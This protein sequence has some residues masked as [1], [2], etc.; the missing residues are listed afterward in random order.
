MFY[1]EIYTKKGFKNS[2][3]EHVLSDILGIG[4][5]DITKVEYSPLYVIDGDITS[6]EAETIASEL[7]SDKIIETYICR[8]EKQSKGEGGKIGSPFSVIE[9]WYRKGVTDTVS[10]SVVKAVKDLGILKEIKVKTGH[11]YYLYGKVSQIVLSD[12]A[13]KLLANT[14]VQEYIAQ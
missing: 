12:V 13:T 9:V 7:L 8:S 5:K 3:G 2:H 4:V 14:L 10:E 1:I 6:A 11:K